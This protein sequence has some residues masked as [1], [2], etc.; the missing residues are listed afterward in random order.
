MLSALLKFV[1]LSR[2]I[3]RGGVRFV[4]IAGPSCHATGS[5]E[6]AFLRLTQAFDALTS[7]DP[8]GTAIALVW[9]LGNIALF[10]E[11]VATAYHHA[12]EVTRVD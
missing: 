2:A 3:A 5:A 6:K 12:R 9:A 7:G 4:T 8:L 1:R 11:S 10:L